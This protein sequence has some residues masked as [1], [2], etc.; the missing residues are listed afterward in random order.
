MDWN[1]LRDTWQRQGSGDAPE[2]RPRPLH[3]LWIRVGQRD[4]L[5][6]ALAV[7]MLPVFGLGAWWLAGQGRWVAAGFAAFL[8]LAIAAIPV[9]LWIARRRIPLPDPQM[10]VL[11]FLHEERQ[12]LLEQ[13]RML[14]RVA[15][16]YWGPLGI[17]VI[18][19]FVSLRGLAWISVGYVAVVV[20]MCAVVEYANRAAVRKQIEPAVRAVDEQIEQLEKTGED[21]TGT[22]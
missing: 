15:R 21:T 6:T 16:W 14:S 8:T 18:G 22:D 7:L 19:F 10:P 20:L 17:G 5:E 12:A 2:L 4:F 3:R 13:A 11:A 1:D 9:R